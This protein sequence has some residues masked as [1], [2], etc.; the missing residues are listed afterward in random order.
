MELVERYL[1]AVKFALPKAQRDDVLREL[2]DEILCAVRG[3]TRAMAET[4]RP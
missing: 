2:S 1:P 3:Q 4:S